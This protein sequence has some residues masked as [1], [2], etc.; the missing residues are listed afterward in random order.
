MVQ[1]PAKPGNT[2]MPRP[3]QVAR[4]ISELVGNTP[5]I[6]LDRLSPEGGARILG[7]LEAANPGGSVKDRIGFSMITTAEA[8]GR[9]QPGGTIVEPTSGNTGIG[10]AMAAA[11][12]GY[13][14]VL[15]MPETMSEE[16]RRLLKAYGAELVLTEDSCG[17]HAAIEEAER[18]AAETP[19]C[20]MPRQF[21]NPANPEAHRATTAREIL[22]QCPEL[23]AFV[24]AVGTGGTIT[25]VGSILKAERPDVEVVAVEPAKSPVLGGGEP[26]LHGIQGIGAGFVPECL[27]SEVIDRIESVEDEDALEMTRRL[28]S[29]EGVLVG[30]SSGANLVV[31]QRV[32][33][34]LRPDQTVL[35]VLCDSGERYLT[36]DVFDGGSL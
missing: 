17:M 11:S 7:K 23:D 19:G 34:A 4:D 13:R 25:G 21:S 1:A 26:G 12:R 16:R 35:C 27:D 9:L 33:A 32:A 31:A 5:V 14:M 2:T 15:T 29:E 3:N 30:I 36:T 22:E 8:D 20:L 18:I 24:A 6:R 10:L 28:A